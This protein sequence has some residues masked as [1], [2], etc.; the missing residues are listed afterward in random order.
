VAA[1]PQVTPA[2]TRPR[3]KRKRLMLVIAAALTTELALAVAMPHSWWHGA[4]SRLPFTHVKGLVPQRVTKPP[5]IVIHQARARQ[6]HRR[7]RIMRDVAIGSGAALAARSAGQPPRHR[8]GSPSGH[9]GQPPSAL[10]AEVLPGLA[11]LDKGLDAY[12]TGLSCP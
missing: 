7:R 5:K 3:R 2:L 4:P 12:I 8:Q 10:H 11:A 6:R 9:N 1:R